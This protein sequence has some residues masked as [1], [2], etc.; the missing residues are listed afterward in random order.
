M[1]KALGGLSVV[2]LR[3][4]NFTT[5]FDLAQEAVEF[6]MASGD[7]AVIASQLNH[8][9]QAKSACGD[10]TDRLDFEESLAWFR[11]VDD[12]FGIGSVLQ[13]LAIRE[14]KD[15]NLVAARARTNESLDL[16]REMADPSYGALILLGLVE[17]LDG[18]A[19]AASRA[20]RELLAIARRGG[21]KTA[22][23]YA[24]L[25]MGF[26]ATLADDP[27]RAAKLHG[28]ADALFETLGE[29]LDPDLLNFRNGDHRLLRRTMGDE[30]FE[31]DYQVGRNLASQSV[32]DLAM[33]ELISD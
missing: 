30:A 31:A 29:A 11:E 23:G 15:G 28:A 8:R 6:A 33:Q 4:G 27:R 14:L 21:F 3:E 17:L 18:N 5:A 1:A 16:S 20:Y 22:V 25:G 13:S 26:C 32:F 24:L 10:S 19:P 2:A 12:R 7:L 9:G